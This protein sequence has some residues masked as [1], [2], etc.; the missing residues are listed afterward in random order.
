MEAQILT[1]LALLVCIYLCLYFI[2]YL[3]IYLFFIFILE[4]L[5]LVSLSPYLYTVSSKVQT[6]KENKDIIFGGDE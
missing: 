5:T 4:R 6:N 2:Y 3:F 1:V